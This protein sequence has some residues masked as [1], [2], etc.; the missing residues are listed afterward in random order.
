LRW[1]DADLD[2]RRMTGKLG[3]WEKDLR[4]GE[5][6]WSSDIDDMLGLRGAQP[7]SLEN[8]L[9]PIAGDEREAVA[10]ALERSIENRF[11]HYH[12][13][14][15]CLR[16][17]GTE[18]TVRNEWGVE[19]DAMGQ[20]LLV[21]GVLQDVTYRKQTKAALHKQTA[22]LSLLYDVASCAN[23]AATLEQALSTALDRICV[24][25]GWPVGHVY[26]VS[27]GEE[28]TLQPMSAW[29][30]ADP[31]RFEALSLAREAARGLPASPDG[32][33]GLRRPSWSVD[34]RRLAPPP[35][36]RAA[37]AAGL[38]AAFDL[39]VLV[40]SRLAAVIECFAFEDRPPDSETLK[41]MAHVAAQLGRV[42]ER[43]KVEQMKD[44]F[45]STV[46]HELRTPLTSILGAMTLLEN[47]VL[48]PLPDEAQ[49]MVRIASDSCR[50][51]RRLVDELLDVQKL[52]SDRPS[53]CPEPIVVAAALSEAIKAAQPRAA[54]NGVELAIEDEAP[55]VEVLADRDRFAQVLQNLLSNAERYSPRGERVTVRVVR[56]A[57]WVRIGVEDRGP[58]VPDEFRGRLFQKFSQADASDARHKTGTGLGLAIC[59][60][61]ITNLG[62]TMGYEG[63]PGGGAVFW[64]ELPEL[65][66]G[67]FP[68]DRL[69]ATRRA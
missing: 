15:R 3:F 39:P 5:V 17:D 63:N 42:F 1:E 40:E 12:V 25:G 43:K 46:S 44:E 26:A 13:E 9:A 52:E 38:N 4:T 54:Q 23:E 18:I 31:S 2:T 19:C 27:E 28:R 66:I 34:I 8:L 61:I 24:F 59:R 32:L 56:R 51:L 22:I 68:P 53:L 14:Y 57:P 64:F 45:V 48:G 16:G 20:P 33:G 69:R 6:Q 58:G 55:G 21:R 10:S 50:R 7:P 36:A 30:S 29:Y 65:G 47:G 37:M 67:P 49:E 41:A 62:G 11:E 60:S 35:V